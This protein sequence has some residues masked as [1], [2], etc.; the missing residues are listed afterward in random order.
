MLPIGEVAR[1]AG[2]RPSA[3]RYYEQMGLLPT[4]QRSNGRRQY[5]EDVLLRLTVIRFAQDNGFTLEQIRTLFTGKPY[6]AR[7]RQLAKAKVAELDGVIGRAREMQALLKKA[8]RC[9]CL[10]I[11]ECGRRLR[12]ARGSPTSVDSGR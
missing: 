1:R 7:L 10:T 6:S 2:L 11:E 5:G 9:R 8:L 4:P 12:A 3:V